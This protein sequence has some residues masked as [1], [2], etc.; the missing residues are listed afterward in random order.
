MC[1][2]LLSE[3]C[4]NVTNT[5]GEVLAA[6]TTDRRLHSVVSFI[7]TAIKLTPVQK[8]RCNVGWIK[9]GCACRDAGSLGAAA[10]V[11]ME[12]STVLSVTSSP[13]CMQ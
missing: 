5:A 6:V 2:T 1:H 11:A 7:T 10:A 4:Q 13:G 9:G 8:W 3:L 12:T